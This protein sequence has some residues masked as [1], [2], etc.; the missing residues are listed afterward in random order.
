M[1]T[2]LYNSTKDRGPS[3]AR[4]LSTNIF[5]PLLLRQKLGRCHLTAIILLICVPCFSLPCHSTQRKSYLLDDDTVTRFCILRVIFPKSP[6]RTWTFV[7]SSGYLCPI[8]LEGG[9]CFL[10]RVLTPISRKD[11]QGR[12]LLFSRRLNKAKGTPEGSSSQW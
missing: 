5:L 12:S 6:S 3:H 11:L 4:S 10:T 8:F 9:F 1:K 7:V 2:Q